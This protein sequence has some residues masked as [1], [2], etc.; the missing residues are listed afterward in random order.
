MVIRA[1]WF[2][3]QYLVFLAVALALAQCIGGRDGQIAGL[4]VP[5]MVGS[6]SFL[7]NLQFGQAHLLTLAFSMGALVAFR[8]DRAALGGLL[9][10]TATVFKLFPGLL[11][12]YLACRRRWRDFGWTIT[13]CVVV[14]LIALAVV[15]PTPF[16]AFVR[17]HL[18]RLASGEAFAF[19]HRDWFYVSRNLSVSGIV[20]KLGVLGMPGMSPS[21]S[22][23]VGWAYTVL[24]LVLVVR[25][26]RL[27]ELS[28]LNEAFVW[29]G[30]LCLGSLR[31]PLAPGIYVVVSAQWLLTLFAARVRRWRDVVVIVIA[32]LLIPGTP[33]LS[34]AATD[35]AVALA[36]QGLMLA[37]A[38]RALSKPVGRETD[39]PLENSRPPRPVSL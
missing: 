30:L 17:Y 9:L 8:R 21:V 26:A 31:S 13:A 6:M 20:F 19:V 10:G 36:G 28:P 12:V 35:I 37:I 32:F 29:L 11:L 18:P 24:L 33:K 4:F 3:I 39:R 15:G 16:V 23:G 5:A 7:V 14:T 25:V 38:I 27:G 2:A 22:S 34:S 1:I